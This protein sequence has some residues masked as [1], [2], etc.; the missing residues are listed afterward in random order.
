M[1]YRSCICAL[2]VL[3]STLS[4][5][6]AITRPTT[7]VST[8]TGGLCIGCSVTNANL[9]WDNS[10]TTFANFDA[11]VLGV[12]GVSNFVFA[13]YGFASN[14]PEGDVI[15]LKMA[16]DGGS[17]LGGVINASVFQYLK[18]DLMNSSGTILKSY[19]GSN[20]PAARLL[21]AS[22]NSFELVLFNPSSSTRRIRIRLGSFLSVFP[23]DLEVYDIYASDAAV[24]V[25]DAHIATGFVAD[26][27]AVCVG[28]TNTNQDR[29]T[30]AFDP[31][32]DFALI[33]IPLGLSLGDSYQYNTYDWGGAS[34]NGASQS[35]YLIGQKVNLASAEEELFSSGD[36][37]VV[38]TYSDAS[39]ETFNSGSGV[40]NA[41]ALFSGS[42]RF[43]L[44]L[45][46]ND[47]KSATQVE[48]RLYS[49]SLGVANEFRLYSIY[50]G[51]PGLSFL[52]VRFG[53]FSA[54]AL[55]EKEVI[56]KWSTLTEI[57]SDYFEVQ[58]SRNGKN[59]QVIGKEEAAGFAN[60][61]QNYSF[62]HTDPIGS[63]HYYRLRQVDFDGSV[64]FSP[65]VL[66]SMTAEASVAL[67]FPN[68]A[69]GRVYWSQDMPAD[70]VVVRNL[71]GQDLYAGPILESMSLTHLPA[72]TYLLSFYRNG[73]YLTTEKLIKN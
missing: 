54:E 1:N 68:P 67:F 70:F 22:S 25:V 65:I 56:L 58:Y 2:I 10:S 37:E 14:I 31:N 44:E 52:P 73:E 59:W 47:A 32:S 60:E 26:G 29:A 48:V 21:D 27:A 39:Q 8:G 38:V 49:P 15:T 55:D 13:T 57:N 69:H 64:T 23:P 53:Q 72:D 18:I 3:L 9:A 61:E 51:A 30:D 20:L 45:D 12:I 41:E 36:L 4:L 7:T 66:V 42:G 11:S 6:A 40:A 33:S 28:C 16:Y 63:L 43:L 24:D 62:L 46:L 17:F 5:H 71:L 50:S 35:I 19:D 34:I